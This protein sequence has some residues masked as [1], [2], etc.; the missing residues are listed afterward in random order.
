MQEKNQQGD[1]K[2]HHLQLGFRANEF[3]YLDN[4]MVQYLLFAKYFSANFSHLDS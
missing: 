1:N 2:Q 4:V 3:N